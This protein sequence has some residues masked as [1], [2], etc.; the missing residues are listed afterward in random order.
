MGWVGKRKER[1][2][3]GSSRY[4]MEWNQENNRLGI[5]L[6]RLK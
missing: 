2:E 6:G 5:A 3:I 1:K 4:E